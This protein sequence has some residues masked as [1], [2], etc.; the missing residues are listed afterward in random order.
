MNE[1]SIW[2]TPQKVILSVLF[3][4]ASLLAS[5]YGIAFM[6]GS[7]QIDLPWSLLLPI[8]ITMAFGWRYGLL[9]GL[10]GGAFFPFLLWGE[11]G[12]ANVSTSILYLAFFALLGIAAD[13]RYSKKLSIIPVRIIIA[14]LIYF[15]CNY[16]YDYFVFN[17]MLS[18]NPSFWS[19]H[20]IR[21]LPQ[22]I[23]NGF[24]FKDS[25]NVI[26]LTLAADTLL[27]LPFVRKRIGMQVPAAM[28]SNTFIF[29]TTLCIPIIIWLAF[30]AMGAM[31]LR[32]DNALHYEHKS[33]ALILI[34]AN[35]FLVARL[36]FY[37][38]ETQFFIQSKLNESEEK[39]RLIFENVEDVVYQM[40]F[41]GIVLNISPSVYAMIGYTAE[42]IIGGPSTCLYETDEERNVHLHLLSKDGSLNDYEVTVETKEGVFKHVSVNSRIIYDAHGA[43]HHIDGVIRDLTERKTYELQIETQNQQLQIKN[44]ELEQFAYISSHDLQEPLQNLLSVSHTISEEYK[45]KLDEKA[46]TYL[47]FINQSASRMQE[48]VKGLLNYARIGKS[49]EL[50]KV[51]TQRLVQDILSDIQSYIK[52]HDAKI[53]VEELP[54]VN[55]YPIEL[56]QLF[57]QLIG[58]AIKFRKP[59]VKPEITISAQKQ[60]GFWLF[61]V[62]DNG[63]GIDRKDQEKI[64]MIF[65]RLHNRNE[66]DGTGIGLSHCKK[67]VALHGGNISVHST[68]GKGSTFNFTIPR[69]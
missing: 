25:I 50:I 11:D 34:L 16:L 32:G 68:P 17:R 69:L 13:N 23:L 64:F 10:S 46:D 65:K 4:I 27:R 31:L 29:I 45:G 19:P 35:G 3:G 41:D 66:Y 61:A 15:A 33:F 60:I 54:V 38:S 14:L 1:R 9:A 42:E 56:K 40:D 49:E 53:T 24:V 47:N 26:A 12:W 2:G 22:E 28:K 62:Q 30:I 55:G 43:P 21:Y 57:S 39:Y 37:F 48:L 59:G 63:I 36:L 67:I 44:K 8:F 20:A 58:N 6:L 52:A 51:D 18:L 5:P 7:I